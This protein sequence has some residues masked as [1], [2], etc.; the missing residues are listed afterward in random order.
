M[1]GKILFGACRGQRRGKDATGGDLEIGGQALPTVTDIMLLSLFDMAGNRRFGGMGALQGLHAGF[2]VA[3]D[4]MN[5]LLVERKSLLVQGTDRDRVVT[6]LHGILWRWVE[7]VAAEMRLKIDLVLKNAPPCES[8]SATRRF[9][10]S[11]RRP[12][13][14]ASSVSP[15]DPMSVRAAH[16]RWR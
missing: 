13:P 14:V 10:S 8:R 12:P 16:R 6:K 9:V 2:L 7:P 5:A 4:Q 15:D 11:P 1:V 3:A